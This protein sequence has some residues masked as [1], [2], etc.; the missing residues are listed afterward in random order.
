MSKVF[1]CDSVY[2]FNEPQTVI[3]TAYILKSDYDKAIEAL[4][5][6]ADKNSY[7]HDKD[8]KAARSKATGNIC[9][10]ILL[11]DFDRSFEL[12]EGQIDLAGS[13]ARATLK[14]LGEKL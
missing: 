3:D 2:M 12:E 6:Y 5:F 4:K 14:A 10:D 9:Y 8:L 11:D 13:L 7:H 1:Y